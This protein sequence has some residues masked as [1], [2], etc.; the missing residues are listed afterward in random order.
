MWHERCKLSLM[1]ERN[2]G[3]R[4]LTEQ[5]QRYIDNWEQYF[6]Q[7]G[8]AVMPPDPELLYWIGCMI[9]HADIGSPIAA[10]QNDH[11][12]HRWLKPEEYHVTLALPGRPNKPYTASDLP[13]LVS[14]LQDV[15]RDFPP[16]LLELGNMNCFP[17]VLFREVYSPD[18][19]LF[20]LH[21]A[22]ADRIPA[23]EEPQFRYDN[24]MPHISLCYLQENDQD[25]LPPD[26]NRHLPRT[27]ITV[28]QL[29]FLAVADI[30]DICEQAIASVELGTGNAMLPS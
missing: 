30:G 22:I 11:P 18:G 21:N 9:N 6:P 2:N 10:L 24:F 7:F 3:I 12:L 23:S 15:A 28:S 26:F 4:S 8:S 14:G 16:L 13:S 20:R 29:R 1:T 5:R 19:E 17:H 25:L 27:V